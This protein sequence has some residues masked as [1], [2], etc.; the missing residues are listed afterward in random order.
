MG[1]ISVTPV[2]DGGTA[3]AASVNNQISTIV[4]EFNGNVTDAN[5]ASSAAIALSKLAISVS[6]QANAGTAGGTMYYINLGGIKLLWGVGAP[7]TCA[8]GGNTYTFVMPTSFFSTVT[9]GVG[10][11]AAPTAYAELVATL[12]GYSTTTISINQLSPLGAQT[13]T[14]GIFVIGT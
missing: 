7:Q 14:P 13:A 11:S 12:Q 4:N 5:I 6:T 1:L 3:T 2:V 8:T 9:W 10:T